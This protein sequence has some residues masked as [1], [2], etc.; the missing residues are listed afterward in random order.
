L[1]KGANSARNNDN[2]RIKWE[3]AFW[4]NSKFNPQD[5]LDLRSCANCGLQHDVCGELLCPIDIDW[6]DLLVCTSIHNGV[7]DVN[8]NENFFLCCLYANNCGNPEDIERGF[9]CNQLLLLTFYVIFIS[10]SVDEDHFNELPNHSPWRM[11]GVANTTKSTVATTLNMNGKVTG[12]AIAYTAV[13]LVFN[14]TDA[15]GWAD[16][17]NGFSFYGLYNFLVDYFED[18]PDPTSKAQAGALLAWWNRCSIISCVT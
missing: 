7:L 4:I 1:Q 12:H 17:Y 11:R 13:T 6:S 8:I 15:T 3:V 16:S 5:C 10:P 18:T 14:L 9:L 2:A